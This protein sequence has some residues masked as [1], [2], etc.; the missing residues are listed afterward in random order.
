MD[1]AW[2]SPVSA[3]D[4]GSRGRQFKSGRPDHFPPSYGAAAYAAPYFITAQAPCRIASPGRDAASHADSIMCFSR[5]SSDSSS[6]LHNG[7][8][9]DLIAE[10]TA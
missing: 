3:L 1:G 9:Y 8:L 5:V 6:L 10:V 4:W 7:F 2:R